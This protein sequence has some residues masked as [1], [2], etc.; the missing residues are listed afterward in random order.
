M[1][2]FTHLLFILL[3]MYAFRSEGCTV[4]Y[5]CRDGRVLGGSNEDWIDPNTRMWFYPASEEQHGWIKF[6]FAGGFP[7]AGMNDSGIFWDGTASTWQDMPFSEANKEKLSIPLMQKVMEECSS[8]GEVFEVCSECYCED[9]YRGQYLIGGAEGYS[10]IVDGDHLHHNDHS[11]QVL[12]NFH[13]SNPELGGYPCWR[14]TQAS[15]MLDTCRIPTPEFIGTVLA[16]THQ[17]GKYPTQYSIIFDPVDKVVYL[18]YS[19]NFHE[20]LTLNL[21]ECLSGDT[22]SYAIP[23]IFSQLELLY[24]AQGS[25]IESETVILKWQGLPGSHYEVLV[26]DK[27]GETVY[28]ASGN[29]VAGIP[30]CQSL[31]YSFMLMPFLLILTRRNRRVLAVFAICVLCC[32]S[33]KKE[34]ETVHSDPA[35]EFTQEVAG[36]EPGK[37]YHWKVIAKAGASCFQTGSPSWSFTCKG[38]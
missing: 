24:P 9:Q 16:A 33:C 14:Y 34:H 30:D 36:L 11:C 23:T 17:E 5:I 18:F 28:R 3:V 19:H 35:I 4:F 6:G 29:S 25:I 22:V 37:T 2:R 13:I 12:T 21:E 10:V 7:Q 38:T 32:Y 1:K 15:E 20:F 31:Y 26:T 27:N 8:M